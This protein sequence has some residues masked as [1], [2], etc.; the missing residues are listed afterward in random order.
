M[1]NYGHGFTAKKFFLQRFDG[2]GFAERIGCLYQIGEEVHHEWAE[3]HIGN[4]LVLAVV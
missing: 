2:G 4:V 3:C 1:V